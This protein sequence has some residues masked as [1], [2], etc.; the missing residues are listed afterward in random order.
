MATFISHSA[1]ANLLVPLGMSLALS[2][3]IGISPIVAG[4]FIAIGA[5]LAMALPVSTPPN[6]IAMSTGAVKT[7]DMALVG[8]VVGGFG[9]LL[10]VL[11]A[12]WMWAKLGV[13]P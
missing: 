1:T 2:D 10:F 9:W 7:R 13:M 8:V 5:S 11:V 12:P 3:G 6:A 4:V